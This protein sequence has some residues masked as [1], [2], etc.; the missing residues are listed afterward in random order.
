VTRLPAAPEISLYL[1]DQDYPRGSL[2]RKQVEYLMDNPPYWSFCW[3]GGQ[4]LARYFLDH[5]QWVKDKT[6][7]D[8]GAGSG[9]VGIAAKLAGAR[10][11]I[12]C[13][14][15]EKALDAGKL[16]SHLNQVTLEFSSSLE[17]LME[18]EV[19]SWVIVAADVFYDRDNQS[20]L[21]TL[22]TRFASFWMAD[23]RL[24]GLVLPDLTFMGN[25]ASHTVPDL[26]ESQ[27][28]NRV[29]LYVHHQER[30]PQSQGLVF[31]GNN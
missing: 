11:V 15:D 6:L 16:N 22:R 28:F 7:V 23:S 25:F 9:V 19:S 31:A 17:A 14:R 2:T 13:D 27:E 29:S 1:L 10:R 5:P 24:S 8:F 12:L 4:V 18:E 26:D 30:L 21:T 3:A 20:L